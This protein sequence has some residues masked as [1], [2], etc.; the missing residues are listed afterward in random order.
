MQV[1]TR[2]PFRFNFSAKTSKAAWFASSLL[3]CVF[4]VVFGAFAQKVSEVHL[5]PAVMPDADSP[6]TV[7]DDGTSF[8]LFNGYLTAT[9]N[10]KT[11]D[12]ERIR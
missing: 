12:R 7:T 6:V 9:I 3:V 5:G 2:H 8:I 1:F 4:A 11:G 10:K